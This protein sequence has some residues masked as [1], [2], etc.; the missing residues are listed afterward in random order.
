MSAPHHD[1]RGSELFELGLQA[2]RDERGTAQ[3]RRELERRLIAALGPE[4]LDAQVERTAG[5]PMTGA[6][7]SGRLLM[8]PVSALIGAALLAGVF[9]YATRERQPSQPETVR[10]VPHAEAEL[11]SQ[12]PAAIMT[13]ELQAPF[14]A[15]AL[16]D[17]TRDPL[18]QATRKRTGAGRSKVVAP[19]LA[20]ARSEDELT[21]LQRARSALRD[22]ASMALAIAEQHARDYPQ[23]TFAQERE[24]LAIN[25]LLKQRRTAEAFARA[26]RFIVAHASSPYAV[27]LRAML[28]TKPLTGAA[29]ASQLER[30]EP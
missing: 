26:E 25:A 10:A 11:P 21:L 2:F 7:S 1:D 12:Q 4:A 9:G 14:I 20:R 24:V 27:Q 8:M 19:A 22:D 3:Q 23:G 30:I 13:E 5:Q 6:G 29:G 28:A 15:P 17:P 16:G 18:Q